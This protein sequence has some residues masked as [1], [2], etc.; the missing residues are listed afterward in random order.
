MNELQLQTARFLGIWM[1]ELY[2]LKSLATDELKWNVNK[3]SSVHNNTEARSRIHFL[4]EKERNI[5]Y[6]ECVFVALVIQHAKRMRHIV[7]C[8]L[9]GCSVCSHNIS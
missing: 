7:I 2:N 8:G 3:T 9:T 5:T 1:K 6:S 4:R